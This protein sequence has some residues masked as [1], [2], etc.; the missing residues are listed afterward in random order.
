M[1][2]APT[3]QQVELATAVRELLADACPPETVRAAWGSEGEKAR[4][5]LWRQLADLGLLGAVL[6]EADGGLGLTEVDLVPLMVEVGRAAVPLPVAE[7][8]AVLVP[9]LAGRPGD[10]DDLTGLVTGNLVGTAELAGS[11]VLPWAGCSDRA[12]V[13]SGSELRLVDLTGVPLELVTTVDG[14]RAAAR[15]PQLPGTL[16]ST[17][18][19]DLERAWLRGALATAAQLVGLVHRQLDLAVAHAAA[20]KQF[21]VPIGSQ[22][23]VKHMLADVL[24]DVRFALPVVQRAAVSLA[25]GAPE[26]RAHVAAAKAMASRAADRAARTTIQAHG[27]IGY[28]VEYD[29]HLYVKRAWALADTWGS[30]THSRAVVAD[31]LGLP[32]AVDPSVLPWEAAR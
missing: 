29:L 21:G 11:G 9:L 30:E 25:A 17:D 28:T 32:P 22:Q 4:V 7:T 27:A 6:P 13:R 8:V 10:G 23:A 14:S 2:F 19:A 18:P 20:R 16:L 5:D 1:R 12:L 26:A 31:S 24:L 3:A 15:T